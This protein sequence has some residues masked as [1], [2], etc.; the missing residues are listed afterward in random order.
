MNL[1]DLAIKQLD[2]ENKDMTPIVVIEYAF[3]IRK[4]MDN[5]PMLA[6]YIL[7]GTKD[8]KDYTIQRCKRKL[9]NI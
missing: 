3:K 9:K 5:Y 8:L 2:K 6:R 4:W 1:F 7:D